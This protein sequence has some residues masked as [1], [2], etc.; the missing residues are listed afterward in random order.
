MYKYNLKKDAISRTAAHVSAQ[1]CDSMSK[2]R[3][4]PDQ[5]RSQHVERS[6]AHKPTPGLGAIGNCCLPGGE[7]V[8]SKTVV[9]GELTTLAEEDY[10]YVG[11]TGL[12]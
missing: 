1:R 10:E 11:S 4:R 6:W 7:T 2:T 8:F 12:S 5:T 3:A 9:P